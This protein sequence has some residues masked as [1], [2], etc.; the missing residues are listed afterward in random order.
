MTKYKLEKV[1]KEKYLAIDDK[2]IVVLKQINFSKIYDKTTKLSELRNDFFKSLNQ[3]F[4]FVDPDN[5]II[6]IEE[7]I[8]MTLEDTVNSTK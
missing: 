3:L 6:K 4:F 2:S 5:N 8:N 7:E 1:L